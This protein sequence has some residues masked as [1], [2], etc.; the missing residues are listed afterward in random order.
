MLTSYNQNSSSSNDRHFLRSAIFFLFQD[1]PTVKPQIWKV[2]V[3]CFLLLL[4][5]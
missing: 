1:R 2:T 4:V 3:C 5:V